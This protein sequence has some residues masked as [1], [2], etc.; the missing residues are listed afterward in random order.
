VTDAFVPA[1]EPVRRRI[2]ERVDLNMCVEA[3]AGTGKTSVLVDRIVEI[4]GQGHARIENV[5]VITFTEK[6][7]A[8]LSAR[9]RQGLHAASVHA[10]DEASRERF[11]AALRALN[12]AHIETIHAFAASLLR[13][14]PIEAGLAPGFEV[15]TDLPAQLEFETAYDEWLTREMAA[16]PPPAAL[17]DALNLDLDF[18]L[19]REAAEKLHAYRDLLPLPEYGGDRADVRALVDGI[20]AELADVRGLAP[21]QGTADQAYASMLEVCRMLDDFETL[22]DDPKALRRAIATAEVPPSSRGNQGNWADP[23]DC[24]RVKAALKQIA[25]ELQE[26]R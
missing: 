16:D 7:A 20:A 25:G 6:A 24:S 8:E 15:L 3:G 9:V 1:D 14:R 5:A 12:Q 23:K 13:E 10:A 18:G 22:R 17:V 19:V 26:C 21:R 2:R 4:I 11:E